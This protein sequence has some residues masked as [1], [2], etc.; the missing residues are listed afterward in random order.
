M[1]RTPDDVDAVDRYPAVDAR[2]VA[3]LRAALITARAADMLS[4]PPPDDLL[5]D[6]LIR[7]AAHAI[8][9]PEGALFL[10]DHDRNLLIFDT[11]VGSTAEKVKGLTMPLGHGIAGLVAVSRQPIA[12]ANAQ[13]HPRHARDIAAQSGYFPTTILAV[14]VIAPDGTML[15]V[16]ELLD[17][18]RQPTYSLDDLNLLTAF[19]ELAA[20]LVAQRQQRGVMAAL[21]GQALASLTG[22][23]PETRQSMVARSDAFL[24][25]VEANPGTRRTVELA[26]LVAAISE[27]GPTELQACI[28]VLE[29]FADYV[30]SVQTPEFGMELLT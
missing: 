2:F 6:R 30:R 29:V 11:V 3:D 8:P 25:S 24:A 18:Q 16:L 26:T 15:G 9:S 1:S 22:L 5:L 19:A 21:L 17:R 23:P 28:G 12:V 4:A 13:E 14:P 10:L 27:R 7:A 20:L